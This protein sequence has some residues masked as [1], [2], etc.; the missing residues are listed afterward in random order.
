MSSLLTKVLNRPDIWQGVQKSK[1]APIISTGYYEL[2]EKLHYSGWPQNLLTE[3]LYQQKHIGEVQLV[4]PAVAQS[5]KNGGFLFLVDPP[6]MPY[7][8]AW[9]KAGINLKKIRIIKNRQSKESLW[10]A[11]QI[12]ATQG[13]SSC[14]FWIQ[15]N[16]LSNKLLKRLQIAAKKASLLNFIFRNNQA[17]MQISPASLRLVIKPIRMIQPTVRQVGVEILKQPGGWNGQ[18]IDLTI[19]HSSYNANNNYESSNVVA[20]A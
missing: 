9:L 19:N 5:M 4:L 14:L 17:A 20:L 18:K 13:V 1:K 6:F 15:D 10:A 8:P 11:E 16:Y 12:M 3:I 2:D 7:A